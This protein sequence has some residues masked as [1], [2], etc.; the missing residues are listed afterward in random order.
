MNV[1]LLIGK[2]N[3]TGC[4]G[5]NIRRIL[6]RPLVEY[7]FLSLA[8]A[9][10]FDCIFVSTDSPDIAAVGAQYGA[11]HI[12]RP[13][14]LSLPSST[15][16]D[17]LV[18]AYQV[19]SRRLSAA[20]E[21]IALVFAN[22]PFTPVGALDRAISILDEHPDVDSVTSVCECNM[23]NPVRA[24]KVGS[25]GVIRPY[26]DLA[27]MKN[28]SSI[29]DEQESCYFEDFGVQVLR[30]RCFT[31]MGEGEQPFRWMGR[32]SYA[33]VNDFGFDVDAEWQFVVAELWLRE[34]GYTEASTPYDPPA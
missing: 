5:K 33:I 13:A 19:M 14:H 32:K 31:H 24:R 10:K 34:H 11:E 1:G 23:F 20:V 26:V 29:R 25:D 6:G 16:E 2:K 3:S 12:E 18:H 9:R 15:V 4:P 8:N 28:V 17:T 7:G 30:E 21:N 27:K 22:S